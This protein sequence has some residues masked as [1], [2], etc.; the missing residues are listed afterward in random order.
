M[1]VHLTCRRPPNDTV[2]AAYC[3]HLCVKDG[4]QVEGFDALSE[5]DKQVVLEWLAPPF[6]IQYRGLSGHHGTLDGV[7]SGDK[8]LQV[9]RSAL[10]LREREKECALR[11]HAATARSECAF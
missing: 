7:R 2:S 6:Q 10:D 8:T 11:L 3:K 4:T 5:V 9:L 1:M